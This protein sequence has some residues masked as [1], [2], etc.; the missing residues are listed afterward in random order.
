MKLAIVAEHVDPRRGG[1]EFAAR[2]LA[3]AFAD[4]NHDVTL[5]HAY[6]ATDTSTAV[7][8]SQFH[9][10]KRGVVRHVPLPVRGNKTRALREFITAANAYLTD[11]GFDIVHTLLPGIAAHAYQPRGG[12]YPAT[13]RASTAVEANPFTLA[14]RR[15]ARRFNRR[16]QL[17]AR[18][19][20]ETL[21]LPSP[22]S[23]AAVSQLVFDQVRRDYPA[24]PAARIAT[25]FNACDP[26]PPDTP[27]ANL[28][29]ELSIP[30]DA[31]LLLFVAHNFKLKGLAVLL[32]ALAQSDLRHTHLAL[33]GRGRLAPY[34]AL[35]NKHQIADRV[36]A[37][38]PRTDLPACYA[39]A[40]LLVHPTWYDPCSRVVLEA[41]CTGLPVVT[42]TANGAA[43][44][45]THPQFAHLE[46]R[47]AFG[48]VIPAPPQPA[49]LAD[50][51]TRALDPAR[52]RTLV[53]AVP[54]LRAHLS[55]RR[56]AEDLLRFYETLRPPGPFP[57][58]ECFLKT[59]R[60]PNSNTSNT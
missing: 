9:E 15:L 13:I 31:P 23:V 58:H 29:A 54:A 44:L 22:V 52:R 27:P 7:G 38:G 5:I 21:T 32:R 49:P 46:N 11:H 18:L 42:T 47:A 25:V 1:A 14:F 43:E 48:E 41:L 37:L 6:A 10:F 4:L 12:T 20:R 33:V 50:A 56:H 36:H 59:Y 3:H 2:E 19:E 60:P 45:I 57:E 28:R 53:A 30:A 26:P 39:A 51:I 55:M 16:Q 40:D 24:F 17:L 34:R 8:P 35:I